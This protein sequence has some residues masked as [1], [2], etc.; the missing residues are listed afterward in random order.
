MGPIWLPLLSLIEKV[1]FSTLV[2][3]KLWNSVSRNVIYD[4]KHLRK[5]KAEE[6]H[7]ENKLQLVASLCFISLF[8]KEELGHDLLSCSGDWLK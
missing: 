2:C 5:N 1:R 4:K 7:A 3:L 8:R 6:K